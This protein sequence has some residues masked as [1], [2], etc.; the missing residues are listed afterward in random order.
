M[1]NAVYLYWFH[2]LML[3]RG[4]IF[5][6]K[7]FF[8]SSNY[9]FYFRNPFFTTTTFFFTSTT[10]FYFKNLFF[11]FCNL[12]FSSATF[13]LTSNFFLLPGFFLTSNFF[14]TSNWV[15]Y[16]NAQQT[17]GN[18][19]DWYFSI[20]MMGLYTSKLTSFSKPYLATILVFLY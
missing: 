19:S 8:F 2:N 12:F 15:F 10:F 17:W 14:F 18:W 11:H 3:L 20:L 13:F 5:C 9:N 16:S 4:K 1:L 6:C 7:I